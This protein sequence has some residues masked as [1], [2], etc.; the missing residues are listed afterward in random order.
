MVIPRRWPRACP[1]CRSG[2]TDRPYRRSEQIF[3]LSMLL[4]FLR[5]RY[6]RSCARHFW[7]IRRR[8]G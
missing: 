6:C 5:R 1:F 7:V 2:D 8:A 3:L 4:P